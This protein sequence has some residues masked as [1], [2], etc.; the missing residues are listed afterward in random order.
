MKNKL[1]RFIRNY[2]G[3]SKT[4]SQGIVMLSSLA[5]LLLVLPQF[6]SNML[7]EKK[8][9]AIDADKLKD[10]KQQLFVADT[11]QQYQFERQL[12]KRRDSF[13]QKYTRK[14]PKKYPKKY[15]KKQ[16]KGELFAFD[17]NTAS[18]K[19]LERLGLRAYIARN[20]IKYRKSGGAFRVKRDL[21][22]IYSL[23]QRDYERLEA[24]IQLPDSIEGQKKRLAEEEKPQKLL[25][26]FEINQADTATLRRI[27]GIGKVYAQRIVTYRE[28]LGGFHSAAQIQEVWGLSPEAQTALLKYAQFNQAPYRQI[29]LNSASINDLN[30]HPYI[31][32]NLARAI[33][34]WRSKQGKFNKIEDLKQINIINPEIFTKIAPYL[35]I[36]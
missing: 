33:I 16:K 4:E 22:K 9:T 5:L 23:K 1:S 30:A 25:S 12:Q 18:Q 31:S 14:Y 26:P 10:L 13:K 32:Y 35:V 36:D 29:K 7:G 11:T 19:D 34:G 2:F 21:L 6:Y 20:I 8:Q 3:V 27:R 28:K 15:A 17:P 24:Y